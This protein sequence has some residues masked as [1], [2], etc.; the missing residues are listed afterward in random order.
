MKTSIV[1]LIKWT[2]M[3]KIKHKDFIGAAL[4]MPCQTSSWIMGLRIY[5]DGRTQIPLSSPAM[6]GP[7]ARIQDRQ[8]IERVYTD[9]NIANNN[10]I[11]HIMVSFT[12]H[13]NAIY[14]DRLYSKTKI[15]N[16]SSKRFMKIILLC[17]PNFSSTTR[18]SFFIKNAKNNHS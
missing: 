14:I 11:N 8:G 15:G 13:Y 12:D 3:V 10:K 17:K 6:I 4:V 1:L 2:G 7:L 16:D 9:I 18:T 5:G